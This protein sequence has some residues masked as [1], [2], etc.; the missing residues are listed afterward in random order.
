[1]ITICEKDNCAGCKLCSDVCSI[2]A[3]TIIDSIKAYNAII[4]KTK[5]INCNLCRKLCPQNNVS[6]L[7]EPIEWHQGWSLDPEI[8]ANGS[9]G[10]SAAE[11]SKS[12]IE[13]GGEVL[14][15]RFKD[16]KFGFE[17]FDN[18]E[19]LSESAG[20]KYVKSDPVGVYKPL[21]DKLKAGK[22]VLMIALPCQIAAA[23]SYTKC[24]ENLY[25]IDLICHGTPSPKVL[26]MYLKQHGYDLGELDEISF[27]YKDNFR[28]KPVIRSGMQDSYLMAF[29]EGM[30]FTEN[31][32]SCKYAKSTRIGDVTLGDSW[33]SILSK[34]EINKGIS[35]I[36]CQTQ[37]GKELLEQANLYLEVV[38]K[39]HAIKHNGQLMH[40]SSLPKN[41]DNFME[42]IKENK[43]L[44]KLVV[45][46][47]PKRVLRQS[48]KSF[49]T[50][51]RILRGGYQ[52]G[53]DSGELH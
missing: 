47:L 9:S 24:H 29:L 12:F 51:L 5:C 17:F 19:T 49:L 38:D 7:S 3:I 41:R 32:Y 39:Y 2:G 22:K 18:S 16:G 6:K 48:V 10:G 4:D 28:L 14:T 33:G 15:C 21:L 26:E 42:Q 11:I 45:R 37:K 52:I 30:S 44:D 20:S 13:H 25:T 36:L 53:V 40:S 50:K 43:N 46:F 1:M 8:R 34:E 31:C 23:K 35:L 27:R